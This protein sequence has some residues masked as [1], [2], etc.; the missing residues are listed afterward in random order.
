MTTA[1]EYIFPARVK[2]RVK[3]RRAH[4]RQREFVKCDAKRIIVKAGRRGGKTVGVAIR[5]VERFLAGRR[6]LYTAP[7]SEQ[8]DAFWYEVCKALAAPIRAGVYHK[9]ETERVIELSGT[10]QRIRAKTAWNADT[11]RGDYA[12]DLT[13]DEW[14]LTNED[15][16]ERVGAPML[17]D[18]DGDAVFIYTPPSLYSAGVSKARDPR[19]A[20]KMFKR[21]QVD[22]TGRWA[23][24]HF[25]SYEN[26]H[27]SKEALTELAGDMSLTAYRQEILAEDDDIEDSW[28]IYGKFDSRTCVIPR[29]TLPAEWPRFVGHDFGGA[30]PAA[31]FIAQDPATGLMYAYHEYLPGGGRSAYEH[32]LEF[33]SI[34]EGLTVLKRVGGSHQEE[35]IRQAYTA[36]GWPI[37]EPTRRADQASAT[38][39][40]TAQID[41]VRAL[42]EHNR[43][44][45]FDDMR[46]LREEISNYLWEI[47][48]DGKT[49][50]KIRDKARFHLCDC[51]RYVASVFQ[52]EMATTHVTTRGTRHW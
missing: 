8:T 42:M 21:A 13:F 39:T 34:T 26:P 23:A 1:I 28:L 29:F 27:I 11:L 33:K 5:H 50:D 14:Q 15:A 46:A 31:L 22:E 32:V 35:E 44:Y 7:T 16:W 41:R 48:P 40:I 37:T 36:Q 18:N 12:D 51:L 9:N 3:L 4:P 10:K 2:P 49:T 30:N 52:P 24:F 25:S 17:A 19:H 6:Q 20:S 43:L 38:G 47:A 45:V